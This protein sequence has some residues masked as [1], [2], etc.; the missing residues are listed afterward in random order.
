MANE[1]QA[2]PVPDNVPDAV[3]SGYQAQN[4][5]IYAL[6][7]GL[8]TTEPFDGGNGVISVPAGGIVEVNGVMFRLTV[9]L[10]LTKPD[11]DTAYWIALSDNG[12][13][14]TDV[15]LVD[16]P[17][18]WDSAKK[19]CYRT[20]GRRTLNWVSM[21]VPSGTF[22][23]AAAEFSLAVKGTAERQFCRGWLY[24]ELAS[25]GG[26]G[27]GEN[28]GN[29]IFNNNLSPGGRGGN[30][31]QPN[32]VR[33]TN[34]IFFS[35]GGE[36]EIYVGGT[37]AP[38]GNGGNGGIGLFGG[39]GGGGGGGSGGGERTCISGIADTGDVPPGSGGMGGYASAYSG[40]DGGG[41]G[42]GGGAGDSSSGGA[43][44]G[45]GRCYYGNLSGG[46]GGNTSIAKAGSGIDGAGPGAGATVFSP[47]ANGMNGEGSSATTGSSVRSGGGG[48]GGAGG[49][50]GHFAP[51]GYPG[52]SCHIYSI[53]E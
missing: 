27:D 30:G 28:G 21:G 23:P 36:L 46:T 38:G 20:D 50:S 32:Q 52:G 9:P 13:G 6:Q 37:G 3:I 22:N 19:G 39:G 26:G 43:A 41:H 31:G 40:S 7:T 51:D 24:A 8:D 11:A 29:S 53:T 10:T 33:R 15:E 48:G 2:L 12:D 5:D 18:A 1:F 35:D 17:G 47:G 16:R 25:G 14:T 34:A 45:I 4:T 44:G 42:G 49:S